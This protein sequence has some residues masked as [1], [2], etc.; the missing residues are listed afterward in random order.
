MKLMKVIPLSGVRQLY[1]PLK[2]SDIV[3]EIPAPAKTMKENSTATSVS[4]KFEK[5]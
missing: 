4:N 3:R 5:S 2:S 1:V